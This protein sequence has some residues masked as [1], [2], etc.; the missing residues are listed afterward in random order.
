[1]IYEGLTHFGVGLPFELSIAFLFASWC[2]CCAFLFSCARV[3]F[4]LPGFLVPLTQDL[5]DLAQSQLPELSDYDP[6][7]EERSREGECG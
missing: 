4:V 7:L 2:P 3:C 6:A 1:M 5:S